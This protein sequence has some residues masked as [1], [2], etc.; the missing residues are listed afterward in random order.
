VTTDPTP[1]AALAGLRC[2]AC[3]AHALA[4]VPGAAGAAADALRCD[5]CG[6]RPPIRD[7][8]AL[9]V[10]DPATHEAELEAARATN[11]D[12]YVAEQPD[13]ALS[14]WRHHLAKRRRYVES[15]LARELA[16]R[17]VARA[18]RLLDLGC[19]DGTNLPWLARF[20]ERLY[21]ADYNLLRLVRARRRAPEAALFL[22]DL[23]ALPAPDGYFDLVFFN[24]VIEH[25]ADD[26]AALREAH[27]ILAPGGLLVL[28]TPNEGAFWWQLAYRR[29]P[30]LRAATDHV[31]FYTADT[32]GRRMREAG[33]A[34]LE[35]EHLGWGPPDWGWD[36][37]LRGRKWLDDLFEQVGRRLIPRQASSL[38]LVATRPRV[39]PTGRA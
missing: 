20:A 30:A 18:A 39:A 24:H 37:R 8:V 13:A 35:I 9:L 21:G 23:L 6:A 16:R 27:R 31:H 25:V 11:P 5:G 3:R 38:Y 14:P 2:P 32:I 22:G 19:G 12:W 33:F 1:L 17:G 26:A 4:L 10:R 7:G 36:A 34:L 28:G 15:V 29:A